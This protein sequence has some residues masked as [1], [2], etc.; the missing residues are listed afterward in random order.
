ML[1]GWHVL[2]QPELHMPRG[3]AECGAEYATGSEWLTPGSSSGHVVHP[4]RHA[5]ASSLPLKG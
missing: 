5:A 2:A 4:P 3:A 1:Y